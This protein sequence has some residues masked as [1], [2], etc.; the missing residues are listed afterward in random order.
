MIIGNR[1][2]TQMRG[3]WPR[4]FD[5]AAS[6]IIVDGQDKTQAAPEQILNIAAKPSLPKPGLPHR[7]I[8]WLVA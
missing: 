5:K 3:P 2:A 8:A 7:P 1:S 4:I 6:V